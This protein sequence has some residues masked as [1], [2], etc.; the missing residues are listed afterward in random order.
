MK[1][2]LV[3]DEN[4]LRDAVASMLTA[5]GHQVVAVSSAD[6]GLTRFHKDGPFQLVFVDMIMPGMGGPEFI[7]HLRGTG[8]QV[9]IIGMGGLGENSP[10]G[11][12]V[13]PE[14]VTFLDKPF[15]AQQLLAALTKAF[16]T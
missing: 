3:D 13:Q 2:L 8:S 12:A 9:P 15:S 14:V 6:E 11:L 10:E 4:D 7:R 16:G 1:I 5:R